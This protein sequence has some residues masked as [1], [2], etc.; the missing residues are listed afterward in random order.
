[1]TT[2]H[3]DTPP[4]HAGRD[5]ATPPRS[6]TLTATRLK[7]TVVLN[8]SELRAITAPMDQ[9]AVLHIKLPKRTITADIASKSLRKAQ[10][11]IRDADADNLALVLQG[12][13]VADE[14]DCGGRPHPTVEGGKTDAT[15][16]PPD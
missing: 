9:R 10:S 11:A 7:V 16:D 1:M 8:A 12:H 6:G 14:M 3:L 5:T 13:L 2:T 15:N 4:G